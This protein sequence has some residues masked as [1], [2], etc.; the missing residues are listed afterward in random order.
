MFTCELD[1]VF[2]TISISSI[3]SKDTISPLKITS[4]LMQKIL[5]KE[6]VHPNFLSVV[7]SFG[8]VPHIAEGSSSHFAMQQLGNGACSKLIYGTVDP[9]ADRRNRTLVPDSV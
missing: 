7:F 9:A 1:G 8:K 3:Y 2:L 4:D 6:N 5:L